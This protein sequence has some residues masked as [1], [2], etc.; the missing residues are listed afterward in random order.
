MPASA[1]ARQRSSWAFVDEAPRTPVITSIEEMRFE[2][3]RLLAD[4]RLNPVV[5]FAGFSVDFNADLWDFTAATDLPVEPCSLKARFHGEPY[6]DLLKLY[7]LSCIVWR[8]TKVQTAILYV[9]TVDIALRDMGAGAKG[10]RMLDCGDFERRLARTAALSYSHKTTEARQLCLFLEFYEAYFGRLAD[11]G[12]IP[13]VDRASAEAAKK[14]AGCEGWQAIPDSY[15]VPLL[16]CCRESLGCEDEPFILRA[17][18]ACLLIAS[19]VGMRVSELCALETGSLETMAGPSGS[20]D[21]VYIKFRTFKGAKG[22]GGYRDAVSIVNETALLGYEWLAEHCKPYREKLGVTTLLVTP[23]QKGRYYTRGQMNDVLCQYALRH[24]DRI[25]CINTEAEFPGLAVTKVGKLAKRRG[26]STSLPPGLALSPD[27][28]LV[29]PVFHQFR[30]TVATKLY[31]AGVDMR[32]I[33]KQMSHLSEDMTA[34]YI[35]SDRQIEKAA[36]E[37]VYDA[38][39]NDGAK[40]IGPHGDEFARKVEAYVEGLDEKVKSDMGAVVEAAAGRYPLRRKVGGVCIRCGNVVPCKASGGTDEI[41]CAFGVCPNQCHMFFMLPD[42]LAAVRGHMGLVDANL[43][44]GHTK[45]AANELRKAQNVIRSALMPE[46]EELESQVAE[47]GADRVVEKHPSL[48][49]VT[50]NMVSIKEEVSSWLEMRI[51]A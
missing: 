41:Y 5:E 40:L 17:M 27:D 46:L 31:E 4:L 38:L 13:L 11:P 42:A 20:P 32:Y 24:A 33:R 9:R 18:A 6:D 14:L 51:C 7:L 34:G 19:Q 23:K 50:D 45:A 8:R 47:K 3:E 28:S 43:A 16:E 39:L 1:V 15:L 10:V 48:A 26:A 21:L 30:V 29:H 36:S 12:L 37:A 2:G 35:R 49:G 22:D 25:P 44:A